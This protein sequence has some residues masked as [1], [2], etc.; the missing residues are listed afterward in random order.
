MKLDETKR[1]IEPL[2]LNLQFFA[3]GDDS[4]D[5]GNSNDQKDTKD[6]LTEEEIQKKIEAESDRKL[7]KALER[8]Q[9]EWEAQQQKAID[10]AL[11]EKERLSKLSE[12]EREEAQLTKR[13][14][15]LADREA[16]IQRA[17]LKAEAV[18]DLQEKGLP[19]EF[20]DF[21]LAENAEKTLENI[22]GFKKAFDDAVNETVKEKLRQ[23]TPSS[24]GGGISKGTP[25]L[26]DLANEA[27]VIK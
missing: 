27:R 19:S 2:K 18:E 23:D 10:D 4:A 20:A 6:V 5:E 13:E 25:N 14:K 7:A 22:N 26:Q 21:L 24:G 16:Q 8:K 12:K 9:K 3:D 11:A 1:S 17:E 15:E